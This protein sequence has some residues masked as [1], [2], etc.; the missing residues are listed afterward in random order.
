MIYIPCLARP[1]SVG[2]AG[3]VHVGETKELEG[4]D[5]VHVVVAVGVVDL[6]LV[7]AAAAACLRPHVVRRWVR[8]GEERRQA[9]RP[10]WSAR[11]LREG[12]ED[13]ECRAL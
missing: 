3:A 8:R 10:A 6:E 12:V 13:V 9:H 4:E 5:A 1:Q 2:R 11:S 7:G